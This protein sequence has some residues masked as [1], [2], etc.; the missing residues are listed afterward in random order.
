MY[1]P[2]AVFTHV[3][4]C[5]VEAAVANGIKALVFEI[6]IET[7]EWIAENLGVFVG[8]GG[9]GNRLLHSMLPYTFLNKRMVL[10]MLQQESSALATQLKNAKSGLSKQNYCHAFLLDEFSNVRAKR[11]V[12]SRSNLVSAKAILSDSAFFAWRPRAKSSDSE[13]ETSEMLHVDIQM[14]G[15]ADRGQIQMVMELLEVKRVHR[16]PSD[17]HF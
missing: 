3:C 6:I 13:C 2:L 5:I 16:G 9:T 12:L 1:P 14:T 7:V 17:I 15:L 4:I 11:A 8:C 10:A